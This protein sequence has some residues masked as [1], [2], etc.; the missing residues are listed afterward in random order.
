MNKNQENKSIAI[1]NLEVKSSEDGKYGYI[2]GVANQVGVMDWYGDITKKGAFDK[3]VK[4]KPVVLALRDHDHSKIIGASN[5]SLLKD[6]SL[7]VE[8]KIDKD[9]Q[10]GKETH[11]IAKTMV[12]AGRPLEFSIGF[13]PKKSSEGT[14][15]DDC[16]VR[17]LEE[18]EVLEVSV[19]SIGAN[20]ES[21]ATDVKQLQDKAPKD[22]SSTLDL[23]KAKVKAKLWKLIK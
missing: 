20:S 17:Y 18:V 8:M 5:L 3:T 15:D 11:S 10:L 19:V 1:T 12:E 4:E 21:R 13:I 6:G 23:E 22:K 9:V 2:S 16:R 14:I 7:F